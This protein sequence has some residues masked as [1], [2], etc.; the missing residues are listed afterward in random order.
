MAR[1]NLVIEGDDTLRKVS[2][3]VEK[4]DDRILALLDDMAE[5]MYESNGVGIAAPQVGVLKRIF[6]A[7]VNDGNGL[8]EFINPRIISV[9]GIQTGPEGCLSCPGASG[10]VERPEELEI[11][12]TDRDGNRFRLHATEL[13]AVC[14]S[15]EYDHLEGILFIDKVKGELIRS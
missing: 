9:S 15:H 14:I 10:E 4:I 12:A 3:P 1:R 11:E 13:L 5:T 8:V 7:D 2:R 6:V